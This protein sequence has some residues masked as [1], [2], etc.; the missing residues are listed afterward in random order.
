[1]IGRYCI[2]TH[3]CTEYLHSNT[4]KQTKRHPPVP[5]S[6]MW[7]LPPCDSSLYQLCLWIPFSACLFPSKT[8]ICASGVIGAGRRAIFV[9]SCGLNQRGVPE[10][11][12]THTHTPRRRQVGVGSVFGHLEQPEQK[13]ERGRERRER[14]QASEIG[15][16]ERNGFLCL[17]PQLHASAPFHNSF[18]CS[19]ETLLEKTALSK[20]G[21]PKALSGTV[22]L[23]LFSFSI[24]CQFRKKQFF[25]SL[26]RWGMWELQL[27]L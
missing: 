12:Q 23:L 7:L 14:K 22:F 11:G 27:R 26:K 5:F 1:M 17:L 16:R 13:G 9:L 18:P 21:F 25:F 8:A 2:I 20:F 6:A 19:S 4:S 24:V 3:L 10:P 15:K